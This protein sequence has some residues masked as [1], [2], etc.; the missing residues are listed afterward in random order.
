MKWKDNQ[1]LHDFNNSFMIID[2]D[3]DLRDLFD[4]WRAIFYIFCHTNIIL[5]HA[6]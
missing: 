6:W 4:V 5:D 1:K 2:L 3:L